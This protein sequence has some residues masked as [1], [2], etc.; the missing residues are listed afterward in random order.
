MLINERFRV[1]SG[2]VSVE[3]RLEEKLIVGPGPGGG[4]GPGV[5]TGPGGGLLFLL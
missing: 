1:V 3:T 4:P 5:G 2:A